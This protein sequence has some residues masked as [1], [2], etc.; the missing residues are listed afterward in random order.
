MRR[1]VLPCLILAVLATGCGDAPE[2]PAATGETPSAPDPASPATPAPSAPS[3]PSP[4]PSQTIDLPDGVPSSYADDVA[5]RD[6]PVD[7]LVPPGDDVTGVTRT[8][9]QVEAVVVTF[10]TPGPDPF[11]RARGFVV[12]RRDPG[13]EP[14]WRAVYGVAHGRRDGV[15]AI[16]ADATDLTDDGSADVLIREETGGSGQCAT[17]RVIDLVAG[18][19]IWTRGVCDAE[20]QPNPDPIGLFEVARI[21]GPDDAHCCPSAIRERVLVWNG[22]R[23]VVVSEESTSL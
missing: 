7:D 12:W 1:L 14:P 2:P 16:S 22:E 19:P 17:Y 3:T 8:R 18:A 10:A 6:L 11:L 13:A 23:F 4:E 5:G 9:G 15:L 21:F 20:I